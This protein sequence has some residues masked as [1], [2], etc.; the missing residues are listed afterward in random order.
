M[1]TVL[2]AI[3]S[4]LKNSE[5][6]MIEESV[7]VTENLLW[8]NEEGLTYYTE[9]QRVQWKEEFV[10]CVQQTLEEALVKVEVYDIMLENFEGNTLTWV[11]DCICN[12]EIYIEI[13]YVE[14]DGDGTWNYENVDTLLTK[15]SVIEPLEEEYEE[16]F[17][18]DIDEFDEYAEELD[19]N[20]DDAA[21]LYLQSDVG[22]VVLQDPYDL[23][24]EELEVILITE[25]TQFLEDEDELRRALTV[26][27]ATQENEAFVV[28]L[29]FDTPRIDEK[30]L[31]V[32]EK[33]GIYKVE[34]R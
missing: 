9:S 5:L 24:S 12:D 3:F 34:L 32:Q 13:T 10:P 26:D 30:N 25:C 1:L 15:E 6:Q 27:V 16:D 4:F 23:V 18:K 20:T 21:E 33:D 14:V 31:Y 2:F 28:Y 22:M 11:Y 17:Y 19:M 29:L 7:D 8:V